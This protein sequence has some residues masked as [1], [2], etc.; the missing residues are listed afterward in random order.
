MQV[1][2][3]NT[4][5][6]GQFDSQSSEVQVLS[7]KKSPK[8]KEKTIYKKKISRSNSPTSK[9]DQGND[10]CP[11]QTSPKKTQS[12]KRNLRYPNKSEF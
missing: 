11:T 6:E 1:L 5:S 4:D 9:S 3:P 8:K 7:Y 12:K 2:L 10:S